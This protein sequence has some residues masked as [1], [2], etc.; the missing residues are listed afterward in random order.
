[1]TGSSGLLS[2]YINGVGYAERSINYLQWQGADKDKSS[3][4]TLLLENEDRRR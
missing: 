3:I 2:I 4:H 1:M